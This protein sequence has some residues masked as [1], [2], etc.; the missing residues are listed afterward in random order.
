MGQLPLVLA[1]SQIIQESLGGGEDAGQLL[2]VSAVGV[3]GHFTALKAYVAQ[4]MDLDK[5]LGLRQV[6][7]A[8]GD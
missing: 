8:G 6:A 1:G 3:Y 2:A 4:P 7:A 5:F